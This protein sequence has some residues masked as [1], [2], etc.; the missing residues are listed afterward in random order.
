MI[1]GRGRLANRFLQGSECP[2]CISTSILP[3]DAG[4]VC[5]KRGKG[6]G[7][8]MTQCVLGHPDL[9]TLTHALRTRDA[10]GFYTQLGFQ[11]VEYLCRSSR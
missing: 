3:P 8:W 11:P 9:Q 10:H 1:G 4:F 2:G 6:L 5:R 7:K